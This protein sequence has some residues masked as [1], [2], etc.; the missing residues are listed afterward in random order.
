[1][2]FK[3]RL[4]DYH[5]TTSLADYSQLLHCY[6]FN[7]IKPRMLPAPPDPILLTFYGLKTLFFVPN[8]RLLV[9][10]YHHR[11]SI[12][13]LYPL[14]YKTPMVSA[15]L[16]P[17]QSVIKVLTEDRLLLE[18]PFLLRTEMLSTFLLCFPL[19]RTCTV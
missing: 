4:L 5:S 16:E 8:N 17:A 13:L 7:P 19:L 11:L 15:G 9:V 10:D 14:S 1:M 12:L 2:P 6:S 18:F 3:E